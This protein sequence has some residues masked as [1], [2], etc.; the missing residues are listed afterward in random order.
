MTEGN[1]TVAAKEWTLED[2]IDLALRRKYLILVVFVAVF[3]IVLAYS[4]TRPDIYSATVT[5]STEMGQ[6]AGLSSVMPYRYYQMSKPV[7]YYLAVMNSGLYRDKIIK[8]AATDSILLA[9]GGLSAD[10]T[11]GLI[12]RIGLSK[13]EY[14]ELM[15]MSVTANDPV[16]AY[17]IV[18]I[19]ATAYKDRSREIQ[20]EEAR[21]TVEYVSK[22]IALAEENLENAERQLQEFKSK[23]KF[24]ATN[25]ND[26]I[27]QRLNEIENKV[28][29]LATQ[30]QLAQANLNVYNERLGQFEDQI[31]AG[32]WDFETP[33]IVQMR[34][35][36]EELQNKKNALEENNGSARQINQLDGDINERKQFLRDAV[37]KRSTD[38]SMSKRPAGETQE[39][40]AYQERKIEEELNLFTL[41]N[42]ERYYVSLRDSYRKQHPNM[43]E[44]SI[45]LAKLQRA[46]TVNETLYNF[47]IQKGEEA[48]IKAA[49]G[50]GGVKVISPPSIPER[51]IPQNTMRQIMVGVILGLGLGFGLAF[52]MDFIDKSIHTPEEIE[53][54][55]GLS[56]IGTIPHIDYLKN[57]AKA[58]VEKK[59]VVLA[60]RKNGHAT[61]D[62]DIN[63][64]TFQL[65]PLLGSKN[66]LVEAYRNLRTD[67]QFVNV[68]NQ[69]KSIMMTSATPGEGKSLNTA[70]LAI[71][72]SELGKNVLIV[73]C[74]MRKPVQ[75]RIFQLEKTPGLTEYLARGQSL[76]SV[77][78]K[79]AISGLHLISAGTSPPNPAEM[80]DSKR[81]TEL[82][83]QL[84][85]QFDLVIYDTPPLIAVSDPKILAP[86]V[87]TVLLVVRAGKVNYHL[88]KDA[89]SRLAK[90][91]AK[92]IGAVLNGVG[93]KKGY[94]YYYRYNYYYNS[95][96]YTSGESKQRR[97]KSYSKPQLFKTR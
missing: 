44:H 65:L 4:F 25:V 66:P 93:T 96:Y 68:D 22:Q 14:S 49:T 82:I 17:R 81:M 88:V 55:L 74:D 39:V 59:Q 63:E 47:L 33:E 9:H 42:Q 62:K 97:K 52:G 95:E 56:V 40:A 91:D 71:S 41:R 5:F 26:G 60:G 92:V 94:G 86:K 24:T 12:G 64:R 69:I 50:T 72:F 20:E 36:I 30:R 67:L 18:D 79:T 13:E 53:R 8:A 61:V 10:E 23:T 48:K 87:G 3:I 27:I 85:D 6:D 31:S 45:E 80:L 75:H 2:Y 76:E 1:R 11:Y 38:T 34:R 73:D 57:K 7:E 35:E 29:E 51:P 21:T 43:L 58:T 16:V 77:V 19:A 37:L 54:Y 28:T 70:N 78:Q 83:S 32:L 15:Y 46:K 90:V 89:F 84:S